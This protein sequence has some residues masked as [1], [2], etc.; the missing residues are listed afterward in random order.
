MTL[1]K[2]QDAIRQAVEDGNYLPHFAPIHY[3][4]ED[5]RAYYPSSTEYVVKNYSDIL[6]DPAFWIALGKARGWHEWVYPFGYTDYPKH[7]NQ[8]GNEYVKPP[9]NIDYLD[10]QPAWLY[11]ALRYFE[12]KLSGGDTN[13][14]FQNLS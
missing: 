1:K 4:V 3:D 14:F 11:H 10:K 7:R 2:E 9:G 8:A 13:K 5:L 6:Q 12:T